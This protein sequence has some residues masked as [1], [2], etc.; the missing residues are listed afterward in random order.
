MTPEEFKKRCKGIIPVQY[1]PFTKEGELDLDGLK[2]NTQFLV[3]FAKNGKDLVIMTNGSTTEFYANSIEEQKMVIKK[4]V[5]VAGGKVPVVAGTSQAGTK[6]TIKMT[7]Y[8]EGIGVDCAMVVLPYYHTPTRDGM[9]Q[10]YKKIAES[11]KI[12]I[13]IYNNPDVSG[14]LIDPAL[15]QMLSK[16]DNIVAVKD[17]TPIIDDYFLNSAT[18]NPE[19]MVLINGRGEIQYVGSAAY[20]FRYKGFVTWVGN[21][22]P[23]LS[24]AVYETVREKN[25]EKAEALLEKLLPLFRIVGEFMKRRETVSI[26]P[27]AYRT[28]YMYMSVGKACMDL[29]GLSGGPLKLPMENLKDEE[30]NELKKVLEE[31][32]II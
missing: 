8:A 26:I 20:G 19:D 22:A 17:N 1:C 32:G 3:D 28:N 13:M 23:P 15:M 29:V 12:G 16:I 2:R 31:I 7:E 11:V 10:H 9:Y 25:F 4:V 6:E 5:E 24:Y 21:F 30:K 27:L 14:S 18:V